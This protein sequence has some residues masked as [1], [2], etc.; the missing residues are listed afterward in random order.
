MIKRSV[1]H[2]G[3]L[4]IL[5]LIPL[6]SLYSEVPST[7]Q[8]LYRVNKEPITFSSQVTLS[9]C[10]PASVEEV[11]DGDTIKVRL[12]APF[13]SVLKAHETV[14]LLGI[15]A[16]ETET[17]PRPAGFFG[18]EAKKYATR[19]LLKQRVLLAFDWDLR[20]RYGRLLAYVYLSDGRCVNK[21]L[22]AEGYAYAY[23]RY[24][25]Q[26]LAEFRHAQNEARAQKRGLWSRT[27]SEN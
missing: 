23:T 7:P 9:R 2:G 18:K 1:F 8:A 3:Y 12:A 25:F 24:P 27:P 20:D 21:H 5:W 6:L 26:F 11:I 19:L 16:P 4:C 17:S 13:P 14:R 10:L 15:D 22:I